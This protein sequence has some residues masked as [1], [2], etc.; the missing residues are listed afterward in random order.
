VVKARRPT[1]DTRFAAAK[2]RMLGAI[3]NIEAAGVQRAGNGEI[4]EMARGRTE[5][6]EEINVSG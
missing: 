4:R 5:G 3:V 6:V 1:C 2:G